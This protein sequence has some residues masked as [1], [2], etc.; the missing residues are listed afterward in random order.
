MN[1]QVESD[2]ELAQRLQCELNESFGDVIM[3]SDTED[4]IKNVP[5][6]EL[7][8]VK[9]EVCFD[10]Q[11]AITVS[12]SA[13]AFLSTHSSSPLHRSNEKRPAMGTSS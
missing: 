4:D 2:F 5:A 13:M 6:Q 12:F 10:N 7:K 9:E 3:L 8:K 1:S 11:Q